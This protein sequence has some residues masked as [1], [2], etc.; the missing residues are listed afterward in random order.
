MFAAGAANSYLNPL[1]LNFR[2]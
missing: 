2:R 1:Q